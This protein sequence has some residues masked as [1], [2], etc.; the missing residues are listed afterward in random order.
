MTQYSY[1]PTEED[2]YQ[3]LRVTMFYY[4]NGCRRVHL[5]LGSCIR[6]AEAEFANAV[7]DEDG[8]IVM[9]QTENTPATGEVWITNN[10][11]PTVGRQLLAMHWSIRDADGMIGAIPR[12]QF[13]TVDPKTGVETKVY[14]NNS[15]NCIPLYSYTPKRADR[16]KAL[17]V[18]MYFEDDR[19]HTELVASRLTTLIPVVGNR[20]A[21][22]S[23]GVRGT[24]RVG[25]DIL[26][27]HRRYHRP[28][29]HGR[30]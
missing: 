13:L 29:R 22:G 4:D 19:G 21:N 2:K 18:R 15:C 7:A 26:G 16:G 8:L 20:P 1:T 6:K 27:I 11:R 12:H 23:F 25:G 30:L 28:R 17:M 9:L 5:L 10:H 14:N 24:A 3:F